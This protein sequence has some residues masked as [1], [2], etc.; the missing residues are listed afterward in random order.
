MAGLAPLGLGAAAVGNL[1]VER[2]NAQAVQTVLDAINGGIGFIDTAPYYGFGLSERRIGAALKHVSRDVVISTKVGRILEPLGDNEEPP[3][4]GFMC[5]DRYRP[6]FDYTADGV[7]KSLEGSLKRL[8]VDRLSIVLVHDLGERTH[9]KDHATRLREALKGAFPR[10]A[11]L[12]DEGVIERIGLGVNETAIAEAVLEHVDLDVVLLAG[13]H[14]LLEQRARNEGVFDRFAARGVG[15]ILGGVFNSG[16]L[17]DPFLETASF[18]YAAAPSSL[19]ARAQSIAA[20]CAAFDVSL[21][22][23]ALAF[24]RRCTGV[25][26][27]LIGPG[28][29][30]ELAQC[31]QWAQ[32]PVPDELW[33]ALELAP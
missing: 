3:D 11:R 5:P 31:L 2:E 30:A 32:T 26:R 15:V 16:V 23:A 22:A 33:S 8:G 10:L 25:E 21:P 19:R 17:I 6:K 18:D 7:V 24:C 4:Y 29:P 9:G 27:V 14:T 13:R 12:K 28:S 1:F 20:T